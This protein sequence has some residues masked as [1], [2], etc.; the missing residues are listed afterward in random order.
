MRWSSEKS[1]ALGVIL[2]L[3]ILI[4]NQAISYK[5]ANDLIENERQVTRAHI[6]LAGLE[7][8]LSNLR[9]AETGAR[10]FIITGNEDYLESYQ[11]AL[12]R[13]AAHLDNLKDLLDDNLTQ[14]DNF[15]LL[16]NKIVARLQDLNDTIALRKTKGFDAA[17][18]RVES[19][20]GKKEMDEIRIVI[21]LMKKAGNDV[22][23]Q[24]AVEAQRSRSKIILTLSFASVLALIFVCVTYNLIR[25]YIAK[26][27]K[28]SREREKLIDELQEALSQ[29]KELSGLLPICASCKNIKDDEGYWSQIEIYL[30][31]HSAAE[32]SHSICPTCLEKL[33]P[34]YAHILTKEH[35]KKS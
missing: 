35:Y 9:D 33:Y 3:F 1:I 10:G 18:L 7:S 4:I 11:Y 28:V 34:D 23:E 32:F 15:P 25:R 14:K 24:R 13:I 26:R 20:V 12:G 5:A 2:F 19:G 21:S 27:K 8:S 30:R 22:L 31:D 17:R 29:V 16:E 6:V